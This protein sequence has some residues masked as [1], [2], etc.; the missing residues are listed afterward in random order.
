MAV[1]DDEHSDGEGERL[2]CSMTGRRWEPLPFPIVIDSGACAFVLPTDWCGHVNLLKTPQSEAGGFFRAANSKYIFNEGQRLVSMMT[3]E[4]AM[5]DMSF[6]VCS[7]TGALGSVSQ[8]CRA[9]NKVAF[10]PQRGP[11]GPYIEHVEIGERLRL[12]EQGGLCILHAKAAPQERQA[13]HIYET[14]KA[15]HWQVNP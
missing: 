3:R 11:E 8:M 9:G 5:R 7:V 15:F 10:N 13:S 12:E 4:G 6:T 14:S 1:T 2:A